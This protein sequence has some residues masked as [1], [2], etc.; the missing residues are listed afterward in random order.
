MQSS[1]KTENYSCACFVLLRFFCSWIV[2][3]PVFSD[4]SPAGFKSSQAAMFLSLKK[5]LQQ[6]HVRGLRTKWPVQVMNDPTPSVQHFCTA[7]S[8]AVC[9]LQ[10]PDFDTPRR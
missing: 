5:S 1:V 10:S 8:T 4:L 6:R 2:F 9:M 3:W 7:S